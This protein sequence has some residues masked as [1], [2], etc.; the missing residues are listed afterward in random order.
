MPLGVAINNS[1]GKINA[2]CKTFQP[3]HGSDYKIY[4]ELLMILLLTGIMCKQLHLLTNA[5]I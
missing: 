3:I 4:E 5:L 1:R 2:K